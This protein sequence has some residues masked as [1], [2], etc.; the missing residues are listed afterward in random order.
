MRR[1]CLNQTNATSSCLLS[2]ALQSRVLEEV[3]EEE[4]EKRDGEVKGRRCRGRV[5]WRI[6]MEKKKKSEDY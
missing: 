5:H 2:V 1:S 3:E 4:K 6:A